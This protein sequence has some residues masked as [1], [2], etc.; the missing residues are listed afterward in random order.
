MTTSWPRALDWWVRDYAYALYWQARALV[1]RTDPA[2]FRG[3][4][5]VPIVVIPGVYET[6]RFLEPLIRA[7]HERGHPVHVIDALR[8]NR[9]PVAEAAGEV[10]AYLTEHDL[11]GV[12]IAAHSKGGLVGK[13]VMSLGAG[14]ARVESMLAVAAPFGGSRYA[15]YL[16]AP[17]LRIFRP[18]DETIV[19][20]SHQAAVNSRIVSV[21][22]QFDPHIPGGSELPGATNVELDTG[23]HFRILANPRVLGELAVLAE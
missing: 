20:L 19:A 18:D 15:R 7:L 3:G 12:V 6:W 22:G 11:H 2:S 10:T 5:R 23:G 4:S 1:D 13:H 16:F 9:R 14:A 21:Y 17:S 8:W